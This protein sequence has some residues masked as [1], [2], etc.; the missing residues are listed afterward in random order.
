MKKKL[1][2]LGI[3][4][5]TITT[6]VVI[7]KTISNSEKPEVLSMCSDEDCI[8]CKG[9]RVDPYTVDCRFCNRGRTTTQVS[10]NCEMCDASGEVTSSMGKVSTCPKCRGRGQN[11]KTIEITCDK[12]DGRGNATMAC[13]SCKGS[14]KSK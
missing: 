1:R 10:V 12:C 11:T 7:C 2:I 8:R 3:F 4:L 5:L 14:G 6:G 13:R 9:S